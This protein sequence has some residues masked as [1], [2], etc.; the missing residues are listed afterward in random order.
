MI[1]LVGFGIAAALAFVAMT[2][3][4]TNEP[5]RAEVRVKAETRSQVPHHRR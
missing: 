5:R 3:G 2:R 1:A 4:T